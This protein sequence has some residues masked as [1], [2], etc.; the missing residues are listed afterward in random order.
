MNCPNCQTDVKITEQNY[1]SLFTCPSCQAAYFINFEGQAE[2]GEMNELSLEVTPEAK[3]IEGFSVAPITFSEPAIEQ[4]VDAPLELNQDYQINA[5]LDQPALNGFAAA[6][7]DISDFGNSDTQV[8]SLNYDLVISGLD[9][10]EILSLFKEAIDDSRFGWESNS[11]MKSIR[12]GEVSLL[13][14][15]PVKAYMLSKRLQFLDVQKNWKQN[16]LS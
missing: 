9:T 16:V 3:A 15:N 8:A 6:A 2:F 5:F 4:V 12:N 1:G 13:R 14:L 11:I 7:Q 10:V